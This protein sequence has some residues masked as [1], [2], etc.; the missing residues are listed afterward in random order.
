[1]IS[2]LSGDI[3]PL[4]PGVNELF[5]TL[6]SGSTPA[7]LAGE[8]S[9]AAMFRANVSPPASS[10][11]VPLRTQG[12]AALPARSA[13][14]LFGRSGGWGIRLAAAMVLVLAVALASAAYT[15]VLP[16][17]MQ[18]LA[19]RVLGPIGVPGPH[20]SG[21]SSHGRRRGAS[22]TPGRP[23]SSPGHPKPGQSAPG[24]TPT[25]PHKS[26]HPS[27]S[28][29]LS[30][31]PS[32]T[33][34]PSVATGPALL[35]ASASSTGIPAGSQVVIAGQFTRSGTGVQGITVQLIERFTGHLVGH[36]AGTGVTNADGNVAVTVSAV[37]ANAVFRLRVPGVA[38]SAK[39]LVIVR[40]P[41]TVVLTPGASGLRDVLMVSTMYARRG[42]VV[43]L[44]VD[45]SGIW[46][47]LRQKRLNAAGRTHFVL[48]GTRLQNLEV[49]AVLVAT[50]RHGASVSNTPTVPPPS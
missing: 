45:K 9:A 17:P 18:L 19:H 14:R 38:H 40:P 21:G 34:S 2:D 44:E 36:L 12:P 15:A 1:M 43:W 29:S 22:G 31:S 10:P 25:P 47:Y 23:G 41:I 20:N 5:R 7:E 39:V 49:R 30:P 24:Q 33:P 3:G 13:R 32:P 6:T 35:T 4:D 28:R 8:Q 42:N 16:Q 48:S 37:P 46:T 27:P 26:A 50:I 11:T